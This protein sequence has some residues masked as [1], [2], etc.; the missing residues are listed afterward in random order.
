LGATLASVQV[1][2][3]KLGIVK[4]DSKHRKWTAE[5][6]AL[7]GTISDEEIAK[8]TRHP[9]RSVRVRRAFLG[10]ANPSPP[11]RPPYTPEEDAW[12]GKETD[13]QV[14]LRLGRSLSSIKNRRH[15]LKILAKPPQRERR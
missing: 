14:T 10:I 4:P 2:R 9:L 11:V 5:E 7:L 12:L 13:Q 8:R 1:R 3:F 6:D 15:L